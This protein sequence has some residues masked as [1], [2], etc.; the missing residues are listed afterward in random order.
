MHRL[1][2]AAVEEERE[3][4]IG[5]LSNQNLQELCRHMNMKHRVSI[6]ICL[7]GKDPKA[8]PLQIRA[9]QLVHYAKLLRWMSNKNVIKV[10]QIFLI[11]LYITCHVI[12][13]FIL[14]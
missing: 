2:L 12:N 14:R 3:A 13:S 5:L 6:T 8:M 11:F 7:L 1:L 9:I 4:E 10:C